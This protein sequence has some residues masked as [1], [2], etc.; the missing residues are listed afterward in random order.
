MKI[1]AQ[2][3]KLVQNQSEHI[4][5]QNTRYSEALIQTIQ[6]QK[7]LYSSNVSEQNIRANDK[8]VIQKH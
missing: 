3:I 1:K 6:L 5:F 2:S 7:H 8:V 4:I